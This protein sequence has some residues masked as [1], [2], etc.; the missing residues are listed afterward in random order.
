MQRD[1]MITDEKKKNARQH[2]IPIE[3]IVN[4]HANILRKHEMEFDSNHLVYFANSTA[5]VSQ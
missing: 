1:K 5:A 2:R 4:K 3:K